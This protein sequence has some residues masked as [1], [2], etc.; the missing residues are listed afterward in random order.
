MLGREPRTRTGLIAER[1]LEA[2]ARGWLDR[3]GA[4]FDAGRHVSSLS[5]AE[6]QLVEIARALSLDARILVMDEPTSALGEHATQALFRA[7]RALAADGVAILFISHRPRRSSRS[8]TASRCCATAGL[9]ARRTSPP[10]TGMR[11]CG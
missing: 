2:A 3:V 6:Q 11:W 5:M 1:A 4:T 8:P 7:M 10:R 9:W